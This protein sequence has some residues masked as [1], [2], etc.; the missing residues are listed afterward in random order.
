MTNSDPDSGPPSDTSSESPP[1][2]ANLNPDPEPIMQ[3]MLTHRE[4][5]LTSVLHDSTGV[6]LVFDVLTDPDAPGPRRMQITLRAVRAQFGGFFASF[7]H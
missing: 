6:Y 2:L 4:L 5:H 7:D 1:N 3:A